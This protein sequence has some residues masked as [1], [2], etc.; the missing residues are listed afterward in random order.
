LVSTIDTSA[1]A[2]AAR[3]NAALE[4]F[5]RH[6]GN[7][8]SA[9]VQVREIT[10]ELV[11]SAR[12]S[13]TTEIQS[14]AWEVA[15]LTGHDD[16]EVRESCAGFLD[17]QRDEAWKWACSAHRA[18][19]ARIR[20]LAST[21]RA[22]DMPRLISLLSQRDDAPNADALARRVADEAVFS[23]LRGHAPSDFL[24]V[25]CGW[26][27]Q[28]GGAK[29]DQLPA[30]RRWL[31]SFHLARFPVTAGEWGAAPDSGLP[32]TGITWHQAAEYAA[33]RGRRLPTEAE[34]EKAARGPD[35]TRYPWG[36]QFLPGRANTVESGLGGP[37]PVDAFAGL[38]DSGY[39]IADMV[40]NAW[41]WTAT[42]YSGYGAQTRGAD[43]R[44]LDDTAD[45][46]LRGGAYDF[47][48]EWCDALNRYRCAPDRGWDT[49]GLRLA[50]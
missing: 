6:C 10:M 36:E 5:R 34:W 43:T 11:R 29:A 4:A 16:L 35:E 31:P 13:M 18:D 14:F 44:R 2:A 12:P 37:V 39:G 28:G 50:A 17:E 42:R 23:Y 47:D 32:A 33:R 19:D 25:P 3:A 1:T 8:E 38:G 40:G 24:L 41:E 20:V 45:R 9:D 48:A 22:Q 15:L 49:H 26:F 7:A 27:T 30:L 46:V 21:L